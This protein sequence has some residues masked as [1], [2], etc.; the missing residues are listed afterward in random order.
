MH[1]TISATNP[2]GYKVIQ[3]PNIHKDGHRNYSAEILSYVI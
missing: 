2:L 3:C 1:L